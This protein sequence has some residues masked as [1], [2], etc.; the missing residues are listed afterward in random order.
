MTTSSKVMLAFGVHRQMPCDDAIAIQ[1]KEETC[2]VQGVRGEAAR[3]RA[4]LRSTGPSEHAAQHLIAHNYMPSR[5]RRNRQTV[6]TGANP[7]V[8]I[9]MVGNADS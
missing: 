2:N 5:D 8:V 7:F 3:Q 1:V 9:S 4:V 6:L